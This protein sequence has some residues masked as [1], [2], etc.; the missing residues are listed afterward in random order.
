MNRYPLWKNIFILAVLSLCVIYATPNIY[1]SQPALQISSTRVTV[2][3]N[4]VNEIKND[5]EKSGINFYQVGH[6]EQGILVRFTDTKNQLA[7][8]QRL[9]EK[10]LGK[11]TVA[12]NLASTTPHWLKALEATPMNLGLDL[13]GG[14]H[15]LME[16]DTAAALDNAYERSVTDMRELL[17]QDKIRYSG[18]KHTSDAIK[19]SARSEEIQEQIEEVIK[20]QYFD[21]MDITTSPT[22]AEYFV[23]AKLKPDAL[24]EVRRLAIAQN[25]NLS[26]VAPGIA[27]ALFA[28][29]LGLFVAIPSVVAYN[30]ISS[31]LSK[32]FVSLETFMDEFTTIFFRQLENK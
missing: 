16:V 9:R 19:I 21:S 4:L 25:T 20:D 1:P 8:A 31:D 15:F 12:L 11:Y 22:S 3:K 17:R 10:Y 30:K 6:S 18:I 23:I 27:E 2:T 14:V 26:V 29:A 28:T 7:A 13:R 5:L 24:K 32:Y